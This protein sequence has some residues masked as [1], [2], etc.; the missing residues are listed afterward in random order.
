MIKLIFILL[1]DALCFKLGYD[2]S[3]I[4]M[5]YDEIDVCLNRKYETESI[6]EKMECEEYIYDDNEFIQDK[7][8]FCVFNV[9]VICFMIC[10]LFIII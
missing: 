1:F 5:A 6:D 7:V 8:K 9:C 4:L 3:D 10:V 2:V